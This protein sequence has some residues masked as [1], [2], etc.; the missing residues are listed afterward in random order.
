MKTLKD[1]CGR[2]ENKVIVEAS[3][4]KKAGFY[5]GNINVMAGFQKFI[6]F[7]IPVISS[8]EKASNCAHCDGE[9]LKS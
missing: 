9:K 2:K 3:L 5:I 7:R 1:G 6:T 8:T 4:R